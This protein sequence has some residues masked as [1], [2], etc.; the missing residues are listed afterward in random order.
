MFISETH[1]RRYEFILMVDLSCRPS[2]EIFVENCVGGIS[3]IRL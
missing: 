1:K 2:R 3:N